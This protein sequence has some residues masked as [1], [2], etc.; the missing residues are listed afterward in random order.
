M[1]RFMYFLCVCMC[2]DAATRLR[3]SAQQAL[4]VRLQHWYTDFLKAAWHNWPTHVYINH[5]WNPNTIISQRQ[6]WALLCFLCQPL[7]VKLL[8]SQVVELKVLKY[9]QGDSMRH[10]TADW[11]RLV[12]QFE[13]ISRSIFL[14]YICLQEYLGPVFVCLVFFHSWNQVIKTKQ[15]HVRQHLAHCSLLIQSLL[16]VNISTVTCATWACER[17]PINKQCFLFSG[18][19]IKTFAQKPLTTLCVTA[20]HTRNHNLSICALA[21]DL[22]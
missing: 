16:S 9:N 6:L 20:A 17:S 11:H 10:I 5:R 14:A 15:C 22:R 21:L 13:G 3:K 4:I 1:Y 2:K 12:S 8:M 7:T 18:W 19:V